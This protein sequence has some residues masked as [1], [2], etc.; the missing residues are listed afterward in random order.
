MRRSKLE[1]YIDIIE[2]LVIYGPMKSTRITY[3]AKVNFNVL[4]TVLKDLIDK[5]LVEV[6]RLKKN[7]VVY[8]ATAKARPL[9]SKFK[10]LT[11]CLPITEEAA[12]RKVGVFY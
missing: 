8:S 12:M 2:A 7:N 9:L 3:K 1:I 4:K 11:D 5:E 10:E 6:R